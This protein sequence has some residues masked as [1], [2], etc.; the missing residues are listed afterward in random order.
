MLL[1]LFWTVESTIK[2]SPA[3]YNGNGDTAERRDA[4]CGGTGRNSYGGGRVVAVP[5]CTA[6][7]LD[8]RAETPK[9]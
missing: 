3:Q 5:E 2:R 4:W 6:I 7:V 1:F 8:S 9:K